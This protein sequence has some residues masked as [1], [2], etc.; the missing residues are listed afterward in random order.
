MKSSFKFLVIIA[1]SLVTWLGAFNTEI[2]LATT[3]TISG[4]QVFVD[5]VTFMIKG[6]GYAPVPICIDPT[7]TPPY[8]DYF[9]SDYS[10]IYGRDLPL[11]RQM[12]ANTIRLWGW[13][14]EAD[15]AD[16][17]NKAYN[18]GK[19]PIY[20]IVTFWMDS[21]Y[22]ISDPDVR[23]TIKENFRNMVAAHKNHPA[24]LMWAI[25]NELNAPWMYGDNLDD[26]FSLI[27]EM[28]QEA[29]L[30]EGENPH[31]VT[32]PL[33][34]TDLI[35]T[36]ATYDPTMCHLDV[37]SLQVYRGIS[38][39]SLF[40]EYATHSA[41]PLA[42][43]EYG[44]D[45]YDDINRDEYEN[46]GIPYQATYA[47]KLWKEME[48]NS[49]VC[50]GGSIMAYSDE[51]WKGKYGQSGP[52]CPDYD[53]CF[54]SICGYSTTSHPD[55]FSN[56]EWW[57]IMRTIDNG[58]DT[59]IMQPRAVYYVL[60]SLWTP[61]YILHLGVESNQDIFPQETAAKPYYTGA[62]SALMTLKY[63][64]TDYVR[65][66]NY[67][68]NA[69]HLDLVGEEM[70]EAELRDA[71]N[72]ESPQEYNFGVL[73][74]NE[75]DMAV[76]RFIHWMDYQVAGAEVPNVPPLVPTDGNYNWKVVRGFVTDI[77]PC[78][79]D[80]I[81]HVP[82]FQVFGLWLNDPQVDGL[83]FNV[84]QTADDFL[85]TYIPIEESYL[86]VVEPPEGIDIGNLDRALRIAN[87]SFARSK[88]DNNLSY[89][90]KLGFDS[91]YCDSLHNSITVQGFQ[92]KKHY[93]WREVIP[94]ELKTDSVF[95]KI[96]SETEFSRVINV[97]ELD[98]D[99]IY[100]LVL[101]SQNSNRTGASAAIM[102]DAETGAFRQATWTY[103]EEKYPR[104]SKKE[105][106]KIAINAL[107]GKHVKPIKASL[108]WS[109]DL[110]TSRFQPSHEMVFR[111]LFPNSDNKLAMEKTHPR[112]IYW[113]RI[114][115]YVHQ[116]GSYEV[117]QR[118]A[119][120]T[121]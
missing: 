109:G 66:Q 47:E 34:D 71:M 10:H 9:I 21:G 76:K 4:R 119:C 73:E 87:V 45:A 18:N 79:Q 55:G 96:F 100:S 19:N 118:K 28:A 49:D 35:N 58:S 98:T 52:G 75:S 39:G 72:G 29:H 44:I 51:W 86:S 117:V 11:L 17:L 12:G 56:E 105:A 33:A 82:D 43:L 77:D 20:V 116:D 68:Y 40:T 60:R 54:Q 8:G 74:D 24:V 110:N 70:D 42:I 38:F 106:I 7:T 3:V 91:K 85:S 59:D 62:A 22:E 23:N 99:R 30:E 112:T 16:F 90:L 92:W 5:E 111:S 95:M 107:K 65:D 46:I 50:S 37:W 64:D 15:H 48:A 108:V 113:K 101:F 102:I 63:L 69:Y 41:K 57:G 84:Y 78:Q 83:G 13:N 27:N 115:V 114:V 120:E 80:N 93:D 89:K 26:L 31:P 88:P 61:Y 97:K 94:T 81:F 32:T 104:I 6:V 2:T 103:K 25:G 1:T 121:Y 14:N 67:L 36:I 53:P